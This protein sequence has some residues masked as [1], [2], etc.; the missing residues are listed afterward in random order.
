MQG[1]TRFQNVS[2]RLLYLT[3]VPWWGRYYCPGFIE[4]VPEAGDVKGPA[5]VPDLYVAELGSDAGVL[6][7]NT[8]VSSMQG[9]KSLAQVQAT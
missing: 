3:L 9:S 4:E 1:Q 8:T 6:I 5:K 7:V 2:I